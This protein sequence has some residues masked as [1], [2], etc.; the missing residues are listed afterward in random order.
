MKQQK[1][2]WKKRPWVE[3]FDW[4]LIG[5]KLWS[6]FP[7]FT[8]HSSYWHKRDLSDELQETFARGLD[9]VR[10]EIS[11]SIGTG[12]ICGAAGVKNHAQCNEISECKCE[13]IGACTCVLAW[14]FILSIVI[15][16]LFIIGMVL[17]CCLKKLCC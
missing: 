11:G 2:N 13:G 17:C 16:I 14:W 10:D 12:E 8:G 15:L 5:N 4:N 1:R 3:F 7:W 9:V 6:F